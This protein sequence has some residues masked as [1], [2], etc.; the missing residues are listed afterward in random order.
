MEYLRTSEQILIFCETNN[1]NPIS[2]GEISKTIEDKFGLTFIG[3]FLSILDDGFWTY[4]KRGGHKTQDD[5]FG[6]TSNVIDFLINE[7]VFSDSSSQTNDG[8]SL[9]EL[10]SDKIVKLFGKTEGG[11]ITELIAFNTGN[12]FQTHYTDRSK[13]RSVDLWF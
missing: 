6:A 8:E 3:Y 13:S 7:K 11:R 4:K 1:V 12:Y 10:G 2:I 5:K 9:M